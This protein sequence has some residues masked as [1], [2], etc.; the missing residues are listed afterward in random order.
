MIELRCSFS[1]LRLAARC[2]EQQPYH[3]TWRLELRICTAE[4]VILQNRVLRVQCNQQSY[5]K[6]D[7]ASFLRNCDV[8]EAVIFLST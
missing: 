4:V 7:S 6:L 3:A 5:M 8:M 1:P 2:R